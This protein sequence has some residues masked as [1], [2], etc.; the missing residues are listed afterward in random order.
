MPEFPPSL[1]FTSALNSQF[2]HSRSVQNRWLL[3]PSPTIVPSLALQDSGFSFAFQPISVFPS[4]ILIHPLSC[5]E[6]TEIERTPR[7]RTAKAFTQIMGTI[8]SRSTFLM[9]GIEYQVR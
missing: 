8:V 2:L 1:I 5:A 7:P 4:N 9:T 3:S 6:R